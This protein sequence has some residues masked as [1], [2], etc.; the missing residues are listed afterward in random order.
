MSGRV[1]YEREIL[2][3]CS[4]MLEATICILQSVICELHRPGLIEFLDHGFSFV[5][6]SASEQC[7]DFQALEFKCRT[8]VSP[9]AKHLNKIVQCR[10]FIVNGCESSTPRFTDQGVIPLFD[11][12]LFR[13][14]YQS[15]FRRTGLLPYRR[16]IT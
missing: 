6:A 2:P 9:A 7:A 12:K 15:L 14:Y 13:P 16:G 4:Q 8:D 10:R 1:Q 11:R 5:E 3:A